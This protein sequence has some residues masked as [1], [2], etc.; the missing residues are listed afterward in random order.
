MAPSTGVPGR[1][2]WGTDP[3]GGGQAGDLRSSQGAQ[4]RVW[5]CG[6]EGFLAGAPSRALP[7]PW[8][9]LPSPLEVCV[10]GWLLYQVT[11]NDLR[12]PTGLPRVF[13]LSPQGPQGPRPRQ[14]PR[15]ILGTHRADH[16]SPLA[17]SPSPVLGRTLG[18]TGSG[19]WGQRGL[20]TG[21]ELRRAQRIKSSLE[22]P[23]PPTPLPLP[24][25]HPKQPRGWGWT[26]VRAR[27]GATGQPS[28][29]PPSATPDNT[30]PPPRLWGPQHPSRAKSLDWGHCH[31]LYW[32]KQES[33]SEGPAALA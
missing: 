33:S 1:G 22:G 6:Q 24:G 23:S 31:G 19:G 17:Y 26:M 27:G 10:G 8:C 2:G 4:G 14:H 7:Q 13:L 20:G 15:L 3:E 9:P 21:L 29:P 25:Q 28:P 5:L 18:K 16:Q 12:P 30:P 11:P 32:S